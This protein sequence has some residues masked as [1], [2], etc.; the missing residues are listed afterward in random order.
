MKCA[1]CGDA[2]SVVL[3]INSVILVN[4]ESESQ[5]FTYCKAC[6][7]DIVQAI[8]KVAQIHRS[9][10]SVVTIHAEGTIPT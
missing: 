4:G 8:D 10:G 1:D 3:F 2:A 9:G 5:R 6:L 7:F